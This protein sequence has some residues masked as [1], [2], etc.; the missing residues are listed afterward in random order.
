MSDAL[1]DLDA[2]SVSYP[3]RK[4]KAPPFLA[5]DRFS[6]RIEADRPRIIA[7]V[8]ES[9]S[10]KTTL[11]RVV[12]GMLPPTG[13]RMNYAGRS[14]TQM[15][16]PQRASF[17]RE[18]QA[19]F[20]D[21]F[22]IFNPFYPVDHLLEMPLRIFGIAKSRAEERDMIE[23]ALER[24][25][26]RPEQ[27]LGRH[28]HQLSG[29]QRQRIV[30]ARSL[31]LRPRLIVAD[32]PVSMIDAS[33]RANVLSQIQALR[34][35]LGV[36]IIYITHDIAT[37]RQVS[38]EVFVLNQG[39]TVESGTAEAVISNPQHPYTRLLVGSVPRPDPDHGWSDLSGQLEDQP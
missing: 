35:D 16:K 39:K 30:V 19:I 27:V 18:V 15:S 7:I 11:A 26:L 9:G 1:L 36:S 5:L 23:T 28:P 22:A 38:D 2:I 14:I 25:G 29:G 10:G 31:M 13:G 21:P 8:G 17:R 34:D 33:L 6:L 12:L 20:Q 3:S 4:W 24:V 37:A 32:E